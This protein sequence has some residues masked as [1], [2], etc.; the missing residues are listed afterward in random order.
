V[1][2]RLLAC[3]DCGFESRRGVWISVSCVFS[4]TGRSLVQRSL[5]ECGV[6]ECGRAALIMRMP[7][8][9]RDF[10]ATGGGGGG[11]EL[12]FFNCIYLIF[13]KAFIK[14]KN[15]VGVALNGTTS[16]PNFVKSGRQEVRKFKWDIHAP[17]HAHKDLMAIL[18]ASCFPRGTQLP[19]HH[20]LNLTKMEH[21]GNR[22]S[23]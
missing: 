7:W 9:T 14:I 22:L 8:P 18:F 13:F 21:F 4:M 5:T 19:P 3:W 17:M 23:H 12:F 1:G 11:G 16:T 15:G 6:S 2:L 10:C 20:F